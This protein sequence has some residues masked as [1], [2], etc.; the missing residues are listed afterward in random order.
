MA[1]PVGSL[2]IGP[3]MD[4]YGRR[5]ALLSI[6]LVSFVGWLLLSVNTREVDFVKLVIGRILTG[7]ACGLASLPAAVY[8]AE[9][10]SP[11]DPA[12]RSSLVAWSTVSLSA[13]IFL[14]FLTGAYVPYYAVASIATLLA[15]MS[16]VLIAIFLPESPVWYTL[17][18]RHG[19]AEW[20]Q[21][22]LAIHPAPS[23][24]EL[25]SE[26]ESDC[27]SAPV[28]PPPEPIKLNNFR[29]LAKP[30]AY[31]PLLIMTFFFFFQ[32][33]SGV[34][35]MIAYMVD[36]VRDTEVVYFG[37]YTVTVIAGAIIL[38]VALTASLIYPKTGVRSVAIVSGVGTCVSMLFIATFLT[39]RPRLTQQEWMFLHW[40]PFIAILSNVALST[41][42]FLILPWSMLGEV[43]PS[44]VKGLAGG[45]ATCLGYIFK[46]IA[47]KIHPFI[48]RDIG[49]SGVFFFYSGMAFLGTIYVS[50]FLPE[51]KGRSLQE[52]VDSFSNGKKPAQPKAQTTKT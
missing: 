11:N 39:I 37:P 23:V 19:D 17:K 28:P 40:I 43:F 24:L 36:I 9:C 47:V 33:F 29:E 26:L 35:V 4:K 52:I 12:F 32:Q 49:V 25:P 2:L 8:A 3:L 31:K 30:E 21:R 5:P 16:F 15:V 44:H 46:F 13:G 20:A 45:I 51:T 18:G 7:A 41:M 42:G 6:N 50:V 14:V 1:F 27:P 48:I 10:L 22:E 38:G 34:Y